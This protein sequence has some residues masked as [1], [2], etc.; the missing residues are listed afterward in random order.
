MVDFSAFDKKV[1]L[2][3]L[4][5]DIESAPDNSYADVPAGHYV[6]N[7]D[8]MEIKTTKDGKKL[9]FAVQCGIKE[10][11]QRRRKIFFNRVIS[12]NKISEK[13]NDGRAIKS[14]CT[15][16]DEVTGQEGSVQFRN[17]S[18]FAAQVLDIY[19]DVSG[20]I[21]LDV[22]YDPDKFN[23]IQINEVYDL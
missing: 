7:I 1:N 19:Q 2:S 23:P 5:K 3:E 12:G 14:V 13:W 11:K 20:E 6:V 17:Y 21:E 9:M 4:Q 18:D 8:K 10:G 16:I 22:T 15:W